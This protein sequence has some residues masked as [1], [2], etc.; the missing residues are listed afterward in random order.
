MN[1]TFTTTLPGDTALTSQYD[2][3]VTELE[4]RL[5]SLEQDFDK[6]LALVKELNTQDRIR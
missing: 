6:L 1:N 4:S 5:L 2:S 3:R